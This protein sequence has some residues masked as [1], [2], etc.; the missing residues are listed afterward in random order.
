VVIFTGSPC[1]IRTEL[2]I[3]FT[4]SIN[5]YWKNKIENIPRNDSAN[6]FPQLNSIFRKKRIAEVN[7]LKIPANSPILKEAE[8]D[9]TQY[10]K[11]EEDNLLIKLLPDKLN[12]I[13]AHFANINNKI[14]ENNRP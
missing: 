2:K 8:I 14:T 11:D 1:S 12:V 10:E 6:M 13:G 4:N 9:I 5:N 3:E 7:T